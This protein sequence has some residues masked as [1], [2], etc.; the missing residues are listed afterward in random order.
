MGPP[1]ADSFVL[2]LIRRSLQR[3]I[4]GPVQLNRHPCRL[5]T[6]S[7]PELSL[8]LA[9]RSVVGRLSWQKSAVFWSF[10]TVYSVARVLDSSHL[11]A[12][13]R[14]TL[15]GPK[16]AKPQAPAGSACG[17]FLRPDTDPAVAATGHPWPGTAQ[18]ASIPIAQQIS[19]RTQPAPCVAF[20][21]GA[22]IEEEKRCFFGRSGLWTQWPVC[23]AQV[24]FSPLGDPL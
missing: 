3:A 13:R 14:P 18:S 16:W 9:S 12:P 19:A 1:A 23:S 11:F 8:H 10:W 7:A 15:M 6:G 20:G 2:T 5:P 21:G 17:G 24:T 4:H 22:A